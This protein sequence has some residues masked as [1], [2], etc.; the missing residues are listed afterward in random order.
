MTKQFLDRKIGHPDQYI[1]V[2]SGMDTAHYTSPLPNEDRDS[3]RRELGFTEDDF[4]IGTVARLA[5]HKGHDDILDGLEEDLRANPNWRLLWVG[6]GWWTNR[7]MERVRK[8]GLQDQVVHTGLVP[9]LRVGAMMRSMDV[10]LHPSY[11]EGLPRTVPQALL[12]SV[13]VVA[14]DTDGTPEVCIDARVDQDHGTGLLVGVGDASGIR[15]AITWMH[16]HPDE[17]VSIANRGRVMCE[18][19][20][21]TDAMIEALEQVYFGSGNEKNKTP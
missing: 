1:T 15:E 11:R 2:R 19:M 20:F 6:N 16:E 10:L 14:S 21:S 5:Q 17:R 8:M 12:C 4:V 9:Q 13:P 18:Q 3:M 7:L